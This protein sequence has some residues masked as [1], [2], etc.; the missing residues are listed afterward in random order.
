MLV[1][2][3]KSVSG[4]RHSS[5][6][7]VSGWRHNSA[8]SVSG[9]RHNSAISV[10]GW[11]HNSAISV[12]GWR[13]NSAISVS[14]WSHSS[15]I[16]KTSD[17]QH[18]MVQLIPGPHISFTLCKY[19]LYFS[20]VNGT[21]RWLETTGSLSQGRS[22]HRPRSSLS[23]LHGALARQVLPPPSIIFIH[24][25]WSI[26]KAGPTT[27]LDHLYPHCMETVSKCRSYHRPPDDH[28]LYP[29]CMESIS[30]AGPTTALEYLYPHCM[31]H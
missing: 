17:Y 16:Y 7:S 11:R 26:S 9:W 25:A 27:A 8:I 3:S 14:G 24:T 6:I 5:A 29:H 19:L 12:S 30:K 4:W 10:S 21:F 2:P 31:E 20:A 23:T 28:I 22:Y 1:L 13:H 15:S 18:T